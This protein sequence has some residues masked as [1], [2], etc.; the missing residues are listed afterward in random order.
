MPAYLIPVLVASLT[1]SSNL[2]YVGLNATVNAVS[3]IRPLI[4]V[5]KSIL[6]TSSYPI[7][8]LSPGLGV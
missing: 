1:A 4:C 6:H 8:V 2:S 5:P 7:T 3:I